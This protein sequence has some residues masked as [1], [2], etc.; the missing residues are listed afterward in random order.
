MSNSPSKDS[1]LV[2]NPGPGRMKLRELVGLAR[3]RLGDRAADLKTREELEAALF[4]APVAGAQVVGAQVADEASP[5]PVVARDV[6]GKTVI[7][8]DFFSSPP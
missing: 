7:T 3:E 2:E 6:V 8:K 5:P 1:S 4:G